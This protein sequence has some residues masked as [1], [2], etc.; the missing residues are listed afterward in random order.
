[1]GG[2]TLAAGLY[3]AF[4]AVLF[5][6]QRSLIYQPDRSEPIPAASGVAEMTVIPLV[7]AD[8]AR[9]R[10]WY[11]PAAPAKPT[12]IYFHGNAGN[13][14]SRGGKVRAYLDAGFGVL[15]VGYRGYGGNPG[16]PSED[17][18]YADA[19]AALE[20]LAAGGIE[21]GRWVIYGE[22]L[23]TGV[24]VRMAAEWA[25]RGP[26]GALVLEAPFTSL[27]DL[28]QHHYF[29]LPARWLV[30]DRF[31]SIERI[32]AVRTP[33]LVLHGERD[34]TVPVRFGRRLYE[35]AQEPKEGRWFPDAGHNDLYDFGADRA[36]VDF[37]NGRLGLSH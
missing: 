17:G 2:L 22:S 37:V 6:V 5:V 4:A 13:I 31:D 36:V 11:R 32:A 16:R 7:A 1:M 18:L 27:A 9:T 28:A 19:R 14:G 23:G 12:L 26:I 20:H 30:R 3:V 10:S 15:L 8:G 29:Y 24:A 33:V 34:G 25:E 21:P 35:R